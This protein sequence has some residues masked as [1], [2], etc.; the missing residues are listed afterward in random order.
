[1]L[2]VIACCSMMSQTNPNVLLSTNLYLSAMGEM[3]S[4]QPAARAHTYLSALGELP[5]KSSSMSRQSNGANA[6]S[7]ADDY[8]DSSSFATEP[9]DKKALDR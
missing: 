1:M 3:S 9:E 8:M 6:D 4:N 5:A 7:A 2:L